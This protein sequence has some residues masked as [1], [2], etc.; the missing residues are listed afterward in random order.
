MAELQLCA[1]GGISKTLC[2]TVPITIQ[3]V[4][5]DLRACVPLGIT[6]LHVH[7]RANDGIE[8]INPDV[9]DDWVGA[10]RRKYPSLPVGISTGEWIAPLSER[11]EAIGSFVNKPDFASV[12]FHEA[13]AHDIVEA[14]RTA[15]MQ[16]EAG[17][18]NEAGARAFRASSSNKNLLR[19][20]VELPDKPWS[21]CVETLEQILEILAPQREDVRILLHGEGRSAWPALAFSVER[22]W[23]V[24]VGLEDMQFLPTHQTEIENCSIVVAARDTFLNPR[25][26]I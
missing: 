3:E 26:I 6:S 12:N 18:W 24:R 16:I 19:I 7:P 25:Q 8:S 17:I 4:M 22:G 1:N 10:I 13:G 14:L 11:L 23:D 9:V 20:L 5:Q 21:V 15:D 2:R